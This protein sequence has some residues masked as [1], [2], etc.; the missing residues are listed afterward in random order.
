MTIKVLILTGFYACIHYMQIFHSPIS[1]RIARDAVGPEI[2]VGLVPTMGALHEGHASLVRRAVAENDISIATIFVNPT[3]F[4]PNEDFSRYPRTLEAD[5]ALLE[6]LGVDMVFV[7]KAEDIYPEKSYISFEITELDKKLCGAS[8]PGHFNGVLQV[9]SILFHI[10]RPTRAYFGEKDYQQLVLIRRMAQELHLP[11]EVTGCPIVREA[12]GLAMSSRNRYLSDEERKQALFLYHSLT[13][14]KN[15]KTELKTVEAAQTFIQ[16]SLKDYPLV[17]LDYAEV[18]DARNLVNI[19][20]LSSE[21]HPRAFIA[22]FLGK[23][24]LIDNMLLF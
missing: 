21:N 16:H 14:I 5:C 7:P 17:R 20:E 19:S 2:N 1:F 9:V 4:G 22:A 12:D 3:Q 13:A 24:R 6:S 15:R 8:R 11:V 18:L 23:T 10:T